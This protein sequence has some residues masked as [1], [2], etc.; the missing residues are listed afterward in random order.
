MRKD[1]VKP[2]IEFE[3]FE[4]NTAIAAGCTTTVSLGPGDSTHPVCDEY[5]QSPFSLRRS[6]TP[7]D[8]TFYEGSCG[9]YLSSVGSTLLTS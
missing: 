4:L 8:V 5:N 7:S 9:C 2:M 1:Y 6:S 3:D